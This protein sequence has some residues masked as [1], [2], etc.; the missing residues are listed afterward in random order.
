MRSKNLSVLILVKKLMTLNMSKIKPTIFCISK[1]EIIETVDDMIK[2]GKLDAN[3]KLNGS[4]IVSILA[5]VE[6]DVMLAKD[7]NM[8]IR[9]SI[10]E[11]LS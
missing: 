10:L 7:I 1:E 11:T 4:Q 6:G 8:S 9:G 2:E 5:C 3:L